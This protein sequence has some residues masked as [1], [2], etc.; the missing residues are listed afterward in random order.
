M[1]NEARRDQNS[2]P[3][4]LGASNADGLTAITVY[5]D[6]VT[7]RLLVSTQD[8]AGSPATP[9]TY[10]VIMT[11]ANTEY[12][13]ALPSGTK[14]LYVKLRS[15]NALLKIAFVLN[16]SGTNYMT[17]PFGASISLENIDLTGITIYMQSPI[18]SQVA[19][20]LCFT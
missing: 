18:A 17:I 3:S 2:I 1:S 4:L 10:N 7:H 6:P 13:R 9:I 15:L 16:E 11:T 5:V 20:I 14:K 12:S 19:E 8:D